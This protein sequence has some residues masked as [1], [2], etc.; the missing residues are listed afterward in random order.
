MKTAKVSLSGLWLCYL[1]G[2]LAFKKELK[3]FFCRR[4]FLELSYRSLALTPASCS[5]EHYMRRRKS[6]H[7]AEVILECVDGVNTTWLKQMATRHES[8]GVVNALCPKAA[9]RDESITMATHISEEKLDRLILQGRTWGGPISASLH[10]RNVSSFP[11]LIDQ[12]Y[13]SPHLSSL[14]LHLFVEVNRT[15]SH[16]PSNIL[17]NLALKGVQTDFFL[18]I[19]VDFFREEIHFFFLRAC[20]EAKV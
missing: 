7:H 4:A 15:S 13:S 16:Y 1:C 12:I 18:A 11:F 3:D 8:F 20:L 2:I 17:R 5:K 10:V 14:R 19:D 9:D 6:E